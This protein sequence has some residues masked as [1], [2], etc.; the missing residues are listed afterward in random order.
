VSSERYQV[1]TWD[2]FETVIRGSLAR[3][4]ENEV[5]LIINTL[6]D[7]VVAGHGLTCEAQRGLFRLRGIIEGTTKDLVLRMHCEAVFAALLE[8]RR[9][10]AQSNTNTDLDFLAQCFKVLGCVSR[11]IMFIHTFPALAG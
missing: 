9:A 6:K 7:K 10:E 5:Q 4:N 2:R 11:C 1:P 3:K 8:A